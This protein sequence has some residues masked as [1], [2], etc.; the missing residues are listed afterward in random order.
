[1]TAFYVQMYCENRTYF[2]ETLILLVVWS[3]I[4]T[5]NL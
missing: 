2:I 3:K 1:M 4:E 5:G